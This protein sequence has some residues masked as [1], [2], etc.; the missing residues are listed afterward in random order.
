MVFGHEGA[1]VVAAVGPRAT[2]KVG[3]PVALTFA[4]CGLCAH[5]ASNNPAYCERSTDLNMRGD[6]GDEASAFSRDGSPIAGGFF[7]QSSFA[8]YAIARQGNTVALTD[9]IDP[10]LAAPLGCSVQTGVGTV[11]NVL[12]PQRDDAVVIFGAGAVG[13]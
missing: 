3:Q 12:A 6:R 1:G 13:L 10:A 7:G 8:T 9:A 11:L 2:L 5:C 4:N